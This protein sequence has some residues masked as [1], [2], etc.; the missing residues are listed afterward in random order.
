MTNSLDFAQFLR[1]QTALVFPEVTVGNIR[2]MTENVAK[3]YQI[4]F[5][6]STSERQLCW[7]SH[8][9]KLEMADFLHTFIY[10]PGF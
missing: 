4:Y 2:L 6:N 8:R 3:N 5:L 7:I 9:K 10:A 1:T